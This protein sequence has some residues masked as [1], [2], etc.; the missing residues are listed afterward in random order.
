MVAW[1]KAGSS[2]VLALGF[3]LLATTSPASAQQGGVSDSNEKVVSMNGLSSGRSYIVYLSWQPN[4]TDTN[5]FDVF[6]DDSGTSARLNNVEYDIA[7]YRGD[8]LVASS[9]RTGQM[10]TRQLYDFGDEGQ[11]TVKISNIEGS[12]EFIDFPIQ[13]TP[14]SRFTYL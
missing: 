10:T 12:S 4:G 3:L 5:I 14:D 8:Q 6:I 1:N 2:M 13:V 11:C 9:Q 7:L